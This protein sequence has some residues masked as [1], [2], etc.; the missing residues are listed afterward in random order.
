MKSR[1]VSSMPEADLITLFAGPLERLGVPYMI[2]GATAAI[3]Y[4]QPRFTNDLDMVI[5]LRRDDIGRLRAAFPEHEFYVPPADIIAV[6]L[7]RSQRAHFNLLHFDSGYK[8]DLYPAGDDPLHRWALPRRQRLPHA[9]EEIQVAPPE[10]VILR[11]LEYYR[12]GGSAKHRTDIQV[13]LAVSGDKL[14][15]FAIDQWITRLGLEA[16]WRE[17]TSA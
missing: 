16:V 15:H 6:E 12:E 17:I 9:T 3:L 4:G 13:M 10:Y 11:K 2:T 14:D 1:D 8:A 7:A 5:E